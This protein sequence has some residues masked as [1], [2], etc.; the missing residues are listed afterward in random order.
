MAT[1]GICRDIN[2]TSVTVRFEEPVCLLT[3]HHMNDAFVMFFG[4]ETH[5]RDFNA[6][7]LGRIRSLKM[8]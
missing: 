3:W 6:A 4:I 1:K 5:S 2:M 8:V 7:E